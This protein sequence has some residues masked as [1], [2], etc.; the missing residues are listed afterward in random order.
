M[1]S[2]IKDKHSR[3]KHV[4]AFTLLE[5][6]ITFLVI[7]IVAVMSLSPKHYLQ[8]IRSTQAA[9]KIKSDIRYAQSYALSSQKRTRVAFSASTNNYSIYV[10]PSPGS[11]SIISDPLTKTNFTVNLGIGEYYGINIVGANFGGTSDGLVFDAAGKPYSCSS[12]GGSITALSSQ[13]VV[14]LSE[15]VTVTVEPNTGKVQ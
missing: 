4:N 15:G 5:L 10:E 1:I 3:T 11:W 13:G 2:I 7:A 8:Q 9:V 14:T 12:G 6:V